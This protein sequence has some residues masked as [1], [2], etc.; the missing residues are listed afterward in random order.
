VTTSDVRQ[1]ALCAKNWSNRVG[2]GDRGVREKE[3]VGNV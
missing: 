1:I 3:G 2:K